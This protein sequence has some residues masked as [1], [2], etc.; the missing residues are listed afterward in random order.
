[1]KTPDARG[2]GLLGLLCLI[3]VILA[4]CSTALSRSTHADA[5]HPSSLSLR[6]GP[7]DIHVT[8]LADP[9]QQK[10]R[11]SRVAA[12]DLFARLTPV[13]VTVANHGGRSMT[14]RRA[15]MLLMLYGGHH[16]APLASSVAAKVLEESYAAVARVELPVEY[17]IAEAGMK[18]AK[19][20]CAEPSLLCVL[21]L[22][23]TYVGALADSGRMAIER[24][25]RNLDLRRTRHV[26]DDLLA[27]LRRDRFGEVTL[28]TGARASVIVYFPIGA[29]RLQQ[30]EMASLIVRLNDTV[31]TGRPIVARVWLRGDRSSVSY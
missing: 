21:P 22:G 29:D 15:D 3:T 1:M 2:R 19:F 14:V 31:A 24:L 5:A 7:V 30:S 16:F 6:E 11:F 20:L 13:E 27:D 8:M 12:A 25:E 4:G 10:A 17:P 18:T 28:D 9:A 26:V 23:F